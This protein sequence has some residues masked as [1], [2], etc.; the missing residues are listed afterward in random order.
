M[1]AKRLAVTLC[2][3]AIINLTTD[4]RKEADMQKTKFIPGGDIDIA[5]CIYRI[6]RS[7]AVTLLTLRAEGMLLQAAYSS[8]TCSA[9]LEGLTVGAFIRLTGT[10]CEE[11]RAPHGFEITLK[12]FNMLACP[13]EDAALPDPRKLCIMRLRS[14]I[15]GAFCQ[16]LRDNGFTETHSPY[17]RAASPND[18]ALFKLKYFDKDAV[19]SDS[20]RRS[21]ERSAMISDR[22]FE[23][24]HAFCAD[25]HNS[26]RHLAEYTRM[27]LEMN[28][29]NSAAEI[30]TVTEAV[31]N[32]IMISLNSFYK[33]DLDMVSAKA[34]APDR[35]FAITFYDAMDILKRPRSRPDLDP[36]DE[37]KLSEY[38]KKVYGSDFL[39]ITQLP[40]VKRP[41]YEAS[42]DANAALSDGFV[43]LYRGIE[44]A[45]GGRH[46]CAG[47]PSHGGVG[48]GLER[49]LMQLAS[50]DNIRDAAL[51]VRDM[52]NI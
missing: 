32:K 37:R 36:T 21:L 23:I 8:S 35:I 45:S 24:S 7:G 29:I 11:S 19:L 44:I 39:Y 41:P 14:G 17:I 3:E 49:M 5:A 40:A 13:I 46:I 42:S 6:K 25:K 10:V 30:M 9:P 43:L 48:I 50:L 2:Q 22:V 47:M 51:F 20:P 15:T 31:I 28:Y 26:P 38:A 16:Y 12:D 34:A 1:P 52:H 27:D 33:N 18:A 4:L